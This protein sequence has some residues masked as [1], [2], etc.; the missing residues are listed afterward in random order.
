MEA[1]LVKPQTSSDPF[2]LEGRVAIITGAT[3]GIGLATARL[4]LA[5]GGRVS[6]CSRKAEACEAAA[7]ALAAEGFE[8]LAIAAHAGREDDIAALVERTIERF[9]RLDI[10]IANAGTNPVFDPLATLPEESFWRI[11]DTNLAGP[12][13]LARHALPHIQAAGG[14]AM[15]VV[16]SVNAQ[17]GM[18]GSGAYGI[19]KAALEQMA[20]QL[21]VE[22]GH[23]GVRINAVAPGTTRTD[24]IRAL[25]Q[26]DDF[27]DSITSATPLRRIAE[28][29]DVA[30][31]ITFLVSDAARHITGQVITVD[32]GQSIARGL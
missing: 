3:R 4:I 27:L 17:L 30:G 24:M 23:A 11:I 31:A 21:A 6:I 14:G 18:P 9:G 15:V 32:G 8:T 5:R 26:K 25:V 29:E 19:S 7:A 1:I 16:S 28:P 13:R 12:W 22:W 10:V 20:R 2:S